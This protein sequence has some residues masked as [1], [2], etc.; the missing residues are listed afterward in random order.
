MSDG[1]GRQA[2]S[3]DAQRGVAAAGA[4]F[5]R[6]MD[7]IAGRE[8]QA[9]DLGRALHHLE[10]AT[11]T[12]PAD[13]A[14]PAQLRA[15]MARAIDL[16]ADLFR[17]TFD[18]YADLVEQAIG[19]GGARVTGSEGA[20]PVALSGLPGENAAAS[21]WLH[22]PTESRLLAVSLH[23]TDLAAHDRTTVA[24]ACGAFS[25]GTVEVASRARASTTLGIA[26]PGGAAPGAYHGLVLATGMPA[27]SVPVLLVV[28]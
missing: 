3:A 22:N 16:Y 10:A 14:T 12:T 7:E 15:A 13:A 5:E 23:V 11:A 6:I 28:E 17:E 1:D 27:V 9:P 19:A 21:V 4:L 26:I 18:V 25:P 2:D 8:R 20:S 24:G